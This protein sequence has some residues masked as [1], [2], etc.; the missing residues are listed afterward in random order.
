MLVALIV[1]FFLEGANPWEV[2]AQAAAR[3]AQARADTPDYFFLPRRGVGH[4]H[5]RAQPKRVEKH[6]GRA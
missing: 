5:G 3:R 4:P 6:L 1:E 2:A